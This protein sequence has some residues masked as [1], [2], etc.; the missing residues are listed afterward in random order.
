MLLYSACNLSHTAEQPGHLGSISGCIRCYPS[1]LVMLVLI[2]FATLCWHAFRY[3]QFCS[4]FIPVSA[5]LQP[6]KSGISIFTAALVRYQQFYSRFI[7]VSVILQPLYS[8]IS[9]FTAALFRY[10]QFYSRFIP[11]SA[12]LQPFHSGISNFTAALFRNQQFCN[13]SFRYQ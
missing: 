2:S 1:V 13:L 5:I 10:Q 12:I 9:N 7:P 6:L 3:Q 11:V 8:G 4:R